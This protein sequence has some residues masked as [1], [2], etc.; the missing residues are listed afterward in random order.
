[1]VAFAVDLSVDPAADL[2]ADLSYVDLAV[3][4]IIDLAGEL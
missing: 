2:I 1:M 4:G 3:V